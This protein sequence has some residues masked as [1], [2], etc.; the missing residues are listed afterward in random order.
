MFD[1]GTVVW[2]YP[3]DGNKTKATIQQQFSIVFSNPVQGC[4]I[5]ENG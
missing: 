1:P 5:Y 3:A 2:R 4:H